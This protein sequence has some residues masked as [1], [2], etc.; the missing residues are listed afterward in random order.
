MRQ[1]RIALAAFCT[2][3]LYGAC[4]DIPTTPRADVGVG[5]PDQA[6]TLEPVIVVGKC[7][8]DLSA[9]QCGGDGGDDCMTDAETTDPEMGYTSGCYNGGGGTGSPGGTGGGGGGGSGGSGGTSLPCPDYGCTSTEPTEPRSLAG[10]MHRDTIPPADCANPDNTAWQKLYCRST[11]PDAA[12]QEKLLQALDRIAARGSECAALAQIGRD[13]I[14]RGGI[15]VFIWQSGDAGA[16]GHPNT[17]IQLDADLIRLYDP[18][19]SPGGSLEHHLV[20]EIDH[21]IRLGHIDAAEL[22]TPHTAAC[23]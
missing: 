13:L 21:V 7:D 16:Y 14:A 17:G 19:H 12:E 1:G 6:L 3:L 5:D 23:S 20:H 15:K 22:E 10:D 18:I 4:S 11:L 9:D 2:L 8:P